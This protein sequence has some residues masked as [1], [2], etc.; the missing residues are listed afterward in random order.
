M[1]TPARQRWKDPEAAR[2]T[3]EAI[4]LCREIRK[5]EKLAGAEKPK[6]T[7]WAET[8]VFLKAQRKAQRTASREDATAQRTQCQISPDAI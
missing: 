6:V 8:K 7:S 3:L 2:W 1:D 5:L 4:Q